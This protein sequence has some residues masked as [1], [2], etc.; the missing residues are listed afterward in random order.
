MEH[1]RRWW[2]NLIRRGRTAWVSWS[3]EGE[4]ADQVIRWWSKLSWSAASWW[5]PVAWQ[6]GVLQGI[7]H[8]QVSYLHL[9]VIK[10]RQ[11]IYNASQGKIKRIKRIWHLFVSSLLHEIKKGKT[12]ILQGSGWSNLNSTWLPR[13]TYWRLNPSKLHMQLACTVHTDARRYVYCV[14][15]NVYVQTPLNPSRVLG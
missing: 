1:E 15:C 12:K 5:T 10:T 6:Q 7:T 13:R 8:P 11:G 4:W 2:R 9:S 14:I 3:G